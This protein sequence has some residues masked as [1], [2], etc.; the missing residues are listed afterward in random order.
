M[1]TTFVADKI[2]AVWRE[3]YGCGRCHANKDLPVFDNEAGARHSDDTIAQ[4][5]ELDRVSYSITD[6]L[7]SASQYRNQN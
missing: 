6:P 2:E 5:D 7:E 4:G 3:G 1:S